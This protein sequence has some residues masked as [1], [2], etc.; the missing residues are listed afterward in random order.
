MKQ[1]FLKTLSILGSALLLASCGGAGDVSYYAGELR[2]E[3]KRPV[4]DNIL[5]YG[6]VYIPSGSYT[7]GLSDQDI[8][9][10]KYQ[11]AKTVTVQGFYMDETEI[12]NNEYRQFINWVTDSVGRTLV[13]Q[14]L[15]ER[16]FIT[17]TDPITEEDVQVLNYDEPL[18]DSEDPEVIQLLEPLYIPAEDRVYF[19]N[20]DYT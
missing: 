8:N 12:T 15:E 4:W 6:M 9:G 5:P 14:D 19:F 1:R 3:A 13:G 20:G 16:F 18:F 2:G 11:S 10:S 7:A 17:T